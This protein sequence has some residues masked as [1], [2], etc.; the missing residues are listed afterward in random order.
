MILGAQGN[1]SLTKTFTDVMTG[2]TIQPYGSLRY[3]AF[4]KNVCTFDSP[5]TEAD[6]TLLARGAPTLIGGSLPNANTPDALGQSG[7]LFGVNSDVSGTAGLF[8]SLAFTPEWSIGVQYQG[9]WSNDRGLAPACVT[10]DSDPGGTCREIADGSDTKLNVTTFFSL[11]LTWVT[12]P[13][14]QI[15]ASWNSFNSQL[16]PNGSWYNPFYNPQTSVSLTGVF[17]LDVIY[18]D[19]K[20]R[21]EA[22]EE[23]EAAT[24]QRRRNGARASTRA[25]GRVAQ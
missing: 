19:L 23:E 18:L 9:T 8:A 24:A 7:S 4:S 20:G 5:Y 11:G 14:L 3:N 6:Q 15:S 2:L 16:A 13:Y 10:V 1:V 25:S 17:T 12:T 22:D 21:L